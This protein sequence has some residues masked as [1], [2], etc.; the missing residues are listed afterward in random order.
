M[1]QDCIFGGLLAKGVCAVCAAMLLVQQAGAE[2]N[3]WYD[4]SDEE[5]IGYAEAVKQDHG[6]R[7]RELLEDGKDPDAL[8]E[9]RAPMIVYAALNKSVTAVRLLLEYGADPNQLRTESPLD[10]EFWGPRSALSAGALMASEEIVTLLLAAGAD[11]NAKDEAGTTAL[12]WAAFAGTVEMV[13]ALLA[14]GADVSATNDFG[15]TPLHYAAQ[16]DPDILTTGRTHAGIIATLLAAGAD[17]SARTK[18]RTSEIDDLIPTFVSNDDWATLMHLMITGRKTPLH[19]AAGGCG[20]AE[21]TDN[22]KTCM[23]EQPADVVR[24]LVDAGADRYTNDQF[25]K[26]AVDYAEE[27]VA[28]GALGESRDDR[29][30]FLSGEERGGEDESGFAWAVAIGLTTALAAQES[31]LSENAAARL[32]AT[33]ARDVERKGATEALLEATTS[34]NQQLEEQQAE[35]AAVAD[36]LSG[37]REAGDNATENANKGRSGN[38]NLASMQFF[39]DCLRGGSTV[40]ECNRAV[41]DAMGSL[42]QGRESGSTARADEGESGTKV[43]DASSREDGTARDS[44][45]KVADSTQAT[46]TETGSGASGNGNAGDASD[47]LPEGTVAELWKPGIREAIAYCWAHPER[48]PDVNIESDWFRCHG[49]NDLKTHQTMGNGWGPIERNLVPTQCTG[50]ELDEAK[51]YKDGYIL[52]CNRGIGISDVDV[53]EVRGIPESAVPPR[54]TFECARRANLHGYK[55][56]EYDCVGDSSRPQ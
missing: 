28:S 29:Y 5:G 18:R 24:V 11:P 30:Y 3:D 16:G 39:E 47:E 54:G 36:S 45:T 51:R 42:A 13:Q 56:D 38:N 37:M 25:G 22:Y 20:Y 4:P 46:G 26:S 12:H 15:A 23:R 43:S 55:K 48:N 32:A 14:A 1:K 49:P 27:A 9:D 52:M 21:L 33:T 50:A 41:R 17:V 8:Y 31:G 7:L 6:P 10:S 53:A 40:S 19:L 35:I 44:T 2:E 34:L